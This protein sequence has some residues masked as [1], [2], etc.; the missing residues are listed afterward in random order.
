MLQSI[1]INNDQERSQSHLVFPFKNVQK[2]R[3]KYREFF[4]DVYKR[5]LNDFKRDQNEI[6][7]TNEENSNN[8]SNKKYLQKI[9]ED[10][11]EDET[12]TEN[13]NS[14]LPYGYVPWG[15]CNLETMEV[16]LNLDKCGRIT[17]NTTAC[18]GFCKSNEQ[19][20]T[21]TKMKKRSCWAC[22]PYKF[23]N[24]K[25]EIRCIDN[26]KSIFNLRAISACSC[27]KHSDM[28]VPLESK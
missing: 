7:K 18:S 6:D 26:S 11:E 27:F 19:I 16:S 2:S 14:E 15:H 17:F 4:Y 1:Q 12:N 8:N 28:I 10:N 23:V 24:I 3:Y 22:K 5:S 13:V 21:N 9:L 20:I 25:Y